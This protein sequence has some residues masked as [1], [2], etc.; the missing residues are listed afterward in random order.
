MTLYSTPQIN[1]LKGQ[2]TKC[3]DLLNNDSFLSKASS[4]KIVL[5]RKKLHDFNSKL[6]S[7]IKQIE[8]ELCML[9]DEPF[10]T[11]YI[12]EIRTNKYDGELFCIDFWAEVVYTPIKIEEKEELLILLSNQG[13]NRI[14]SQNCIKYSEIP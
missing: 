5:E 7:I 8:S 4:D 13:L 2:I 10:I 3:T 12:Q 6:N 9:I 11:Y 1:R 14:F